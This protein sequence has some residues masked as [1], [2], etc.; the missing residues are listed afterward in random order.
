MSNNLRPVAEKC[1]AATVET[2]ALNMRILCHGDEITPVVTNKAW[3]AALNM[4]ANL[5]TAELIHK[6]ARK[7]GLLKF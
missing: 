4:A 2:A 6:I 5:S 7:N 3:E 1:V